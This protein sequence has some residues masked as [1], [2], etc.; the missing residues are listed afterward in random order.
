MQKAPKTGIHRG[1]STYCFYPLFNVNMDLEDCFQ[2]M[3]DMGAHGLEILADGII[4]GYPYPPQEW[5]NRFFALCDKY[6]II[7][8]EYGH[9]VESRTYRGREL[10][11]EESLAK[12]VHDIKLASHLW[13]IC[14][15][16]K[17]GVI[18]EKLTDRKSVV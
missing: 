3:Y 4:D 9:W 15:R 18:D 17:L 6:E 10:T 1:I 14:M 16:T 8:V 2:I 12:L 7:P 5:I 11:V 13:F